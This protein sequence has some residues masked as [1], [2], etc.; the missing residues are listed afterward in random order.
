MHAL[1]DRGHPRPHRKGVCRTES[2]DCLSSGG[3]VAGPQVLSRSAGNLLDERDGH[4]ECA[5]SG[6]ATKQVS[7]VVVVTSDKCYENREWDWPYRET[8]RLGGR[9]PYS[10]SKAC[11]ELVVTAYRASLFNPTEYN[12]HGVASA[13]VRACNVI[14]GGDWSKDRLIP[15]IM[16]A[17]M[18]E[19]SVT[20]R[21]PHAIRPWQHVIGTSGE[22]TLRSRSRCTK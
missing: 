14:G 7:R 2:R 15:D 12:G 4:G 6:A 1:D 21:N 20:I 13:T 17:F 22:A 9:D 18:E 11:A 3:T 5:R 8:D 10:N 19:R 16:R